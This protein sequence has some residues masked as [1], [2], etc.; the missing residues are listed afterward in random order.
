MGE[1]SEDVF[2]STNIAEE[3]RKQYACVDL[4]PLNDSVLREIHPIPRVD[5]A[6]SQLSGATVFSN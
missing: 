1:D 3:E 4:K 2:A 5:E 6:L